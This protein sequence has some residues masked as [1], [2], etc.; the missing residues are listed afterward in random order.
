MFWLLHTTFRSA[1]ES[2]LSYSGYFL[3][4]VNIFPG[5]FAFLKFLYISA[6]LN[7]RLFNNI[8]VIQLRKIKRL[9]VIITN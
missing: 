3:S 2:Q 1:C 5:Y 7:E 9:F 4:A 8:K 6:I